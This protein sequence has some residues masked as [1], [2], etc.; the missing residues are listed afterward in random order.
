MILTALFSPPVFDEEYFL[1]FPRC[2]R[3]WL[4]TFWLLL[5]LASCSSS[6]SP[7]KTNL[8]QPAPTQQIQ[9]AGEYDAKGG[10]AWQN[11]DFA[12]AISY[13]NEAA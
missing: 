13:W 3:L 6:Q 11:G 9:V 7:I 12:Q 10:L 4:L 5:I 8:Q 2:F 1:P